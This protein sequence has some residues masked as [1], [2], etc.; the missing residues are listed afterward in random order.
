MVYGKYASGTA[1][2]EI[3]V[4]VGKT[5]VDVAVEVGVDTGVFGAGWNGVRVGS[6]SNAGWLCG[7]QAT[8]ITSRQKTSSFFL[9]I[10]ST[11]LIN[12][13]RWIL[14]RV[15]SHRLTAI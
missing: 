15:D 11:M 5:G 10:D 3:G 6:T 2:S 9:R 8:T 13:S 12:D 1:G 7:L 4:A 14:Y